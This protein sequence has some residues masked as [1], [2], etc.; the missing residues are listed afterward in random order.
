LPRPRALPFQAV[1]PNLGTGRRRSA[2]A[3]STHLRAAAPTG[4]FAFQRD[5]SVCL[6][7]QL[8]HPCKGSPGFQLPQMGPLPTGVE[9]GSGAPAGA[10]L[11]IQR[12]WHTALQLQLVG[13]ELGLCRQLHAVA[14]S[15]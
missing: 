8:A 3:L 5:L 10:S 11:R 6:A 7:R 13:A 9:H 1:E 14:L 15:R 4:A 2:H 12:P